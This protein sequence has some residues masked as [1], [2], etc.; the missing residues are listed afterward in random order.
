MEVS[1]I[2]KE[3]AKDQWK[4]RVDEFKASGLS[5]TAWCKTKNIN[6]RT[7]SYWITKF[8]NNT[9]QK[10]KQPNWIALK[11][12]EIEKKTESSPLTVKIGKAVLEIDTEFDPKLLSDV[13]KVLNA[14]C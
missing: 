2:T 8:K 13:L 11:S 12:N 6:L 4:T 1:L 14:L 9:Q 3:E 5:Q 7:F 10:V